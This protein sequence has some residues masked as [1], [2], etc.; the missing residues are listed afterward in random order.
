MSEKIV[1]TVAGIKEDLANGVTRLKTDKN[2]HPDRGSIEEKYN[3]NPAE[4][5]DLFKE[6]SLSGVR[7]IP[8]IPKRWVLVEESTESEN[9]ISS[10]MEDV[11]TEQTVDN[12]LTNEVEELENQPI[13]EQKEVS[14]V[15]EEEF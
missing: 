11:S 7:V 12:Q 8:Y 3:L 10:T 5:R 13:E 4:V 2:Y 1:L 14:S 6:P 15:D 9:N